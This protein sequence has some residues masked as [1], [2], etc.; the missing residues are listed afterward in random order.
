MIVCVLE[1]KNTAIPTVLSAWIFQGE[2][3]KKNFPFYCRCIISFRISCIN[4]VRFVIR[5]DA[6]EYFQ[7]PSKYEFI[8]RPQAQLQLT[9]YS[10]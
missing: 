8:F 1:K 7:L 10:T 3:E 6:A 2:S 5:F 9:G 4:W